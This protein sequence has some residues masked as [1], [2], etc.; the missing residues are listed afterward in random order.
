MAPR[1][2]DI[3]SGRP[4]LVASFPEWMLR[5]ET[6]ER[7]RAAAKPAIVEIAGR[8]SVAA[9]LRAAAEADYDL[10]LPTIAYTG[11]EFGDWRLP[12]EKVEYFRE[13]VRGV[14]TRVDVLEPVVLGALE[15]WRLLCGRYVLAQYRRFGFYTPCIGCHVYLH[16]VRVPLAKLTGCDV[17]VAG[18]RESHGGV[19]KLNQIPTALD[20]YVDLLARFDVELSLPLRHVS[21][22]AEIE[23]LVGAEWGERE[24]QLQCVLSENYRDADGSVP[25]DEEAVRRFLDEFALPLA[26][27]AVDAYL[28]GEKADYKTLADDLWPTS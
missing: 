6:V 13:R 10:F 2:R 1:F 15:L 17:V 23:A 7:L 11:T 22:G 25:Y 26:E 5:A 8:D 14:R 18:E 12:F 21:S 24:G 16:A 3:L 28:A 4:E 9:A 19:V 20:A 27:R